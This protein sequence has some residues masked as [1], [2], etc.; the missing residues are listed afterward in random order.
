M[1]LEAETRVALIFVLSFTK[2]NRKKRKNE[3]FSHIEKAFDKKLIHKEK[4]SRK[5]RY[6]ENK[7]AEFSSSL[8][9]K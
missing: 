9:V 2:I 7:I 4:I 5:S 1:F 6:S 3:K 8:A